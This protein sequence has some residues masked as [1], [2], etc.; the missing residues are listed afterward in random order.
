MKSIKRETA[1]EDLI[2]II[3]DSGLTQKEV[4][5]KTELTEATISK[6]INGQRPNSLTLY[7]INQYLSSVE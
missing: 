3:H 6:V 4:A 5:E 1:G 2:K 7:K